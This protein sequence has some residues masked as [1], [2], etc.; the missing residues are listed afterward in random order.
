MQVTV[1]KL[2]VVTHPYLQCPNCNADMKAGLVFDGGE[3]I[4]P[5]EQS[6]WK[7]KEQY[8]G[9]MDFCIC[10]ECDAA[11]Y[12]LEISVPSHAKKGKSFMNFYDFTAQSVETK[13][14]EAGSWLWLFDRHI[15]VEFEECNG[16]GFGGETIP[17]M[18]VHTIGLFM[19]SE[20]LFTTQENAE[21]QFQF[22]L[23]YI[24]HIHQLKQAM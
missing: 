1:T 19:Q 24:K 3:T 2:D 18:D 11:L 14:V 16:H 17:S 4:F 10:P 7:A 22:F 8:W 20:D 5:P 12:A 6:G 15:N 23:P 13:L 21:K 9:H